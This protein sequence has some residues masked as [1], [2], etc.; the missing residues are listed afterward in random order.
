MK[1]LDEAQLDLIERIGVLHDHM[2]KR[3]AAGRILGLLLVAP[4]AELTFEEIR[5][6]LGLSKSATS[7]SL[8]LL[9][10]VGSVVYR[11]RPG[12]R[13]RYFRKNFEDW[14]RQFIQRGMT[15]FDIRFL[16]AEA[17]DL[18]GDQDRE[19]NVAL[20]RMAGLLDIMAEVIEETHE[21][22]QAERA[23]AEEDRTA[24]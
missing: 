20:A 10:D 15:Y 3:P 23:S 1:P 14:E 11:T 2:G 22:W 19:G 6:A 21:R 9:Q 16:L 18:R 12:D 4:Q 13:K 5:E 7:T 24:T 8:Q 17:I